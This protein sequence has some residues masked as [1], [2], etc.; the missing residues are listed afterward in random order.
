MDKFV[1]V[2]KPFQQKSAPV[3]L[4][5]KPGLPSSEP[6]AAPKLEEWADIASADAGG[7]DVSTL[8]AD[9]IEDILRLFD[10]NPAYGPFVGV[11]RLF[12]WHRADKWGLQPPTIIR[13]IIETKRAV[14]RRDGGFL[15]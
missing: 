10:L 2:E 4:S 12:R 11:D 13:D 7:V 6:P 9:Q 3:K 14:A 15:W 1:R 5:A 8:S